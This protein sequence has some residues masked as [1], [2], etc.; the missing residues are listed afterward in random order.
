MT[1]KR[2]RERDDERDEKIGGQREREEKKR[3]STSCSFFFFD[4]E[5]TGRNLHLRQAAAAAAAAAQANNN[6]QATPF[7]AAARPSAAGPEQQPLLFEAA[8][9][10][11]SAAAPPPLPPPS[12]STPSST[13]AFASAISRNPVV[14]FIAAKLHL[15]PTPDL[16]A[17]ALAYFVQGVKMQV[18]LAES[19]F[20]KDI[21]K[22]SPASAAAALS[23][24]HV[25][26]VCKPLYGFVSDSFPL[27]GGEKRRPYLVGCGLVGAMAFAALSVTPSTSYALA[28]LWMTLSELAI[29]FSDVV[30]DALVVERAR[31][32]S[33]A[34]SGSLQSLCWGAQSVGS[35]STAWV[36]GALVGLVGPRPVFALMACFPLLIGVAAL[37]I[38]E[39]KLAAAAAAAAAGTA[40]TG[41]TTASTSTSTTTTPT[42]TSSKL[43]V[44]WAQARTLLSALRHPAVFG[45]AAFI[46][47]YGAPPRAGSAMFYFY[48][49]ELRFSPEFIG[50]INL[51]DGA[52]QLAGVALFNA[53][54]K[55]VPLRKV[56][57]WVIVVGAAASCT[58][59]LLVTR[60]NVKL[61]IPDKLF[62]AFDSVLLTG[63]GRVALMP[64]LVLAAR[65][66]PPGVEATLYAA[67]MSLSNAG[68]GVGE[69]LV[70]A[71][72]VFFLEFLAFFPSL[73]FLLTLLSFSFSLS[74]SRLKPQA[75]RPA[76]PSPPS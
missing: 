44:V 66:C 20:L 39:R 27:F 67:L 9:S 49:N 5:T 42:P 22:V 41:A 30:V 38:D 52:A 12:I 56:F 51:L 58:Q 14:T 23:I 35:M 8:A 61:G 50:R 55:G 71:G 46:F 2:R 48:T 13:A 6:E 32:E 11:S 60:A 24:A 36:A 62:V 15:D 74:L 25:P 40:T 73:F 19:F 59:L 29:A 76:R 63:L 37:F 53:K 21:L 57:L 47:C 65:L 26:W 1:V 34:T 69:F 10:T 28:V 64:V 3:F 68:G 70:F 43:S 31:G 17:I 45:P 16:F 33:Q 7:S 75:R 72:E 18:M 54:L 4:L